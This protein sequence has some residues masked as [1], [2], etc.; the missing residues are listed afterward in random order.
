MDDHESFDTRLALIE[1][2]LENIANTKRWIQ[3]IAAF[4]LIQLAGGIWTVAEMNFKLDNL[5]LAELEQNVATALTV[6]GDHGTE[7]TEVR[8]DQARQQARYDE[9]EKR[10]LENRNR[11]DDKTLDRFY[12]ADGIRLEQRIQR[13]EDY[14]LKQNSIE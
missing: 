5:N 14:L 7:F 10:V 1:R 9:L 2:D 12:R 4:L 8:A 13:L 6:L 3:G 11:V